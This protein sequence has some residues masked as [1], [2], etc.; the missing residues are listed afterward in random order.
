MSRFD[1]FWNP[2][3]EP[4]SYL[5]DREPPALTGATVW[6]PA[7]AHHP[8]PERLRPLPPVIPEVAAGGS[9]SAALRA[10]LLGHLE[11][12][13]ARLATQGLP[14]AESEYFAAI[15]AADLIDQQEVAAERRR[16]QD[17]LRT[18]Q[19]PGRRRELARQDAEL[20]DLQR[21]PG[22]TRA[23][24]AMLWMRL[25][26]GDEGLKLMYEAARLDPEI[27]ADPNFARRMPAVNMLEPA[28]APSS[29]DRAE[30]SDRIPPPGGTARA[31]GDFDNPLARLARA[32][33]LMTGNRL[34]QAAKA[35]FEAAIRAADRLDRTDLQ[36]QIQQVQA[37][38]ARSY[39]RQLESRIAALAAERDTLAAELRRTRPEAARQLEQLDRRWGQVNAD[40][41]RRLQEA[42]TEAQRQSIREDCQAR[43]E[44]IQDQMAR[45]APD[46]VRKQQEIDALEARPEH[47]ELLRLSDEYLALKQL[48]AS[49]L[50][51][52]IAY[53]TVLTAAG[54][55]A[56]AR[57]YLGQVLSMDPSAGSDPD[58]R[59]LAARAELQMPAAPGAGPAS[60]G[61]G[62]PPERT[63][64]AA[65]PERPERPDPI[66][67]VARAQDTLA[68]QGMSAA[69]P[70]FEQAIAAADA[71]VQADIRRGIEETRTML[72][73]TRVSAGTREQLLALMRLYMEYEHAPATSRVQYAVALANA[74]D[75]AAAAAQMDG[76]RT[77]DPQAADTGT[78]RMVQERISRRQSISEA[79]LQQA[80]RADAAGGGTAQ[81]AAFDD[82]DAHRQAA[83]AAVR[84]NNFQT[85]ARELKRTVDAADRIDMAPLQVR[86]SELTRQ[87][88]GLAS[89]QGNL[90]RR[91]QLQSEIDNLKAV[92]SYPV[93]ARLELAQFYLR[94][95]VRKPDDAR[96]LLAEA[97]E[98]DPSL[99][100]LDRFKAINGFAEEMSKSGLT[101]A[102]DWLRR[103]WRG[104]A[105]DLGSGGLGAAVFFAVA[106]ERGIITRAASALLA[107]G[108]SKPLI[109]RALGQE[110]SWGDVGWGMFN[111]GL[112]ITGERAYGGL[113]G[114]L[115]R[116]VDE[117]LLMEAGARRGVSETMLRDLAVRQDLRSLD[118]LGT[119]LKRA[120]GDRVD[121]SILRETALRSGV[122]EPVVAEQLG[123]RSGREAVTA[124][125]SMMRG[126]AGSL[127]IELLTE[128][129]G[130][131]GLPRTALAEL[132][133]RRGIEAVDAMKEML[134]RQVDTQRQAANEAF[135]LARTY[136]LANAEPAAVRQTLARLGVSG[137]R[138]A[139]LDGRSGAEFYQQA[140]NL[141]KE[142]LAERR[143]AADA[144]RQAGQT[145]LY[146]AARADAALINGELYNP[147]V[148]RLSTTL[149]S[150]W[151][152]ARIWLSGGAAGA[153]GGR[154][155]YSEFL[156]RAGEAQALHG[157]SLWFINPQLFNPG[158]IINK[159]GVLPWRGWHNPLGFRDVAG[160]SSL[161]DLAARSFWNK[162][163]V[164]AY[165]T[166][167]T[168]LL[169]RGAHNTARVLS[170][171]P[172]A[173]AGGPRLTVA[174][175]GRETIDYGR[176]GSQA[177]LS[178][179][180]AVWDTLA[181]SVGDGLAGGF[182]LAGARQLGGHFFGNASLAEQ[183]TARPAAAPT[184][185][186]EL[187]GRS[188]VWQ[189]YVRYPAEVAGYY[190][191][192]LFPA[193]RSFTPWAA[194]SGFWDSVP[195][196]GMDL[197]DYYLQRYLTRP[198]G[199]VGMGAGSWLSGDTELPAFLARV[200][201]A[202]AA[203]RS[204]PVGLP[205][206]PAAAA[207]FS[208]EIYR[209]F[210][211]WEAA[212][213]LERTQQLNERPLEDHNDPLWI[214]APDKPD[215][216]T[217]RLNDLMRGLQGQEEDGAPD[218]GPGSRP[219]P[220]APAQ[221][222]DI[223]RPQPAGSTPD[224]PPARLPAQPGSPAPAQATGLPE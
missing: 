130:R 126:R 199:R 23:N 195:R 101:R 66:D 207:V 176:P 214:P 16:L 164:D 26:Y 36:R 165:S 128:Q 175:D 59:R 211:T 2:T 138:L 68:R 141:L 129:A 150:R 113:R 189:R 203:W 183:V 90:V 12:A 204:I 206:L 218:A 40:G 30:P 14:A 100:N 177:P 132:R 6:Q 91:R 197:G 71:L 167:A 56:S 96:R 75:F 210:T 134:K 67:L 117:R 34:N 187:S 133:T 122:A 127:D 153:A 116:G 24:L 61:T 37:A 88:E 69:R 1:Y 104:L 200:P 18:E 87:M 45:V 39:P 135:S 109:N 137:E 209:G 170:G 21:A 53:A 10:D 64:P 144:A 213:D 136:R 182:I 149:R 154:P 70:L 194:R 180:A 146:Q 85:A 162:Y 169:Y 8:A 94:P 82:P 112:F 17:L 54:D 152:T 92:I 125:L 57:L 171:S 174:V 47:Q 219:A 107:G 186:P 4:A 95:E 191:D 32:E 185:W 159:D 86:L 158:Q 84:Q 115:A 118:A 217:S 157:R 62:A 216:Y 74:G 110:S 35:E 145:G 168:S 15:R 166:M 108:A 9:N 93:T 7:G 97:A 50:T 114:A 222:V 193:G 124:W 52:R 58:F 41:E 224:Q 178:V 221:P 13:Q 102:M 198:L 151:D 188:G 119:L 120:V 212:R 63:T 181:G 55:K 81:Q 77:R 196:Y 76:A 38:Y 155:M 3:G 78:F 27:A 205:T 139:T 22:F 43:K 83:A 184:P 106:P 46:L 173:A 143:L 25:G 111:A 147:L 33:S 72:G 48:D 89:T 51:T 11:R 49:S 172:G 192:R 98:R 65:G 123:G 202:P 208:P 223:P 160:F 220:A 161:N 42:T 99:R 73:D 19:D 28:G 131:L 148:T 44:A 79:D 105:S 60:D 20:H 163:K 140:V 179:G 29:D 201:G 5:R 80:V 121:T 31:G 190:H 156:Q 215:A 103:E 142:Q